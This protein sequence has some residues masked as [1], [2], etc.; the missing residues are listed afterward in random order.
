M[1]GSFVEQLQAGDPQQVGGYRLLGRLGSGGMGRVFLGRSPGG[2]LVAV[3]VIRPELAA[4]E[5]FR[6]RFAREVAA[7]RLVSGFF[8][9]P[10]VD[11]DPGADE[12]WLVTGYVQGLSLADAVAQRGPMTPNGVVA[13][14]RGLA[15]GLAAIH[16]AGVVH[17]DL[18]PSN[19]LLAGDGPRII[20]FG[21]SRAAEATMLTGSGIV[22]GSPGFM[23]P[24][25]A[26]GRAVGPA[27]DI[28]SLGA[29]L[30]Y[31]ATG[32]GP[33]GTGAVSA[34]LYRVVH[35]EPA[36]DG[37]PPLLLPVVQWCLAKD[38]ARRPSPGELLTR[39]PQ[40]DTGQFAGFAASAEAA[41]VGYPRTEMAA[42]ADSP[43]QGVPAGPGNAKA[44]TPIL[45]RQPISAV[46]SR[47]GRRSRRGWIAAMAAVVLIGA[48]AG[49][50]LATHLGSGP[51]S[52]GARL[53]SA[54]SVRLARTGPRADVEQFIAAINAH[55]WS[56]VWQLGGKNLGDSYAAMVA[57]FRLTSYDLLTTL[58]SRGDQVSARI[59][60][61]ET[62]G[63][64]Q[65]YALSYIVEGGVITTGQQTLLDTQPPASGC[66]H[67]QYGADGTAG[68]LFCSDGQ[69]NL[70]VLAYYQHMH[71]RVLDLRA[72]ATP[73]Q[74]LQAMCADIRQRS[75]DAIETDAYDLAQQINN[76]SFDVSPPQEM[77]NGGCR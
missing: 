24:E 69:P 60:A 29:V 70:P 62:T 73:S 74:V 57:G 34:L 7:A 65:T 30:A 28:F 20:D 47:H 10:V 68:P 36:L 16:E 26:E 17:R 51:P 4:I 38:P 8:T 15:E 59:R 45:G 58:T 67:I 75:T 31:A 18:K 3:K 49:V 23:S 19:V 71:L 41:S 56:L 13:L 2:R 52:S 66:G 43:V 44:R 54:V 11:A 42:A 5:D 46:P 9:A 6:A 32:E 48:G 12:P 35:A 40:T 25:Q 61:Y 33:F 72:A 64:V 53:G 37:V 27:S 22:V 14:A 55:D 77:L 63:A 21:I 50:A 39:L 76:W 1:V